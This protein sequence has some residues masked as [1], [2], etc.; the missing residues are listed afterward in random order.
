MICQLCNKEEAR[1]K[2]KDRRDGSELCICE[3]HED[4]NYNL[5]EY[6]EV[7]KPKPEEEFGRLHLVKK[8]KKLFD[9]RICKQ[10]IAAGS[11][12]YTQSIHTIPF[13]TPSRLH[14]ECAQEQIEKGVEIVD[15]GKKKEK[16]VGG[17]K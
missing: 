17:A 15:K 11:A 8:T 6:L 3:W 14:L 13:P 4:N 5:V 12:C 1:F 7:N 10:E 2:V 16:E 9:C